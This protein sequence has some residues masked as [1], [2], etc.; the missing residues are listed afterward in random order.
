MWIAL[1]LWLVSNLLI[2]VGMVGRPHQKAFLCPGLILGMWMLLWEVVLFWCISMPQY[3]LFSHI[4][5][6][7]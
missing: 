4:P 7:S 2:V 1:I 3:A 5:H 6:C